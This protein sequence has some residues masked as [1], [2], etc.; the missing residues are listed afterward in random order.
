MPANA[1]DI[2]NIA[3]Y[4]WDA[5]GTFGDQRNPYSFA[6]FAQYQQLSSYRGQTYYVG[7]PSP[8]VFPYSDLGIFMFFGSTPFPQEYGGGGGK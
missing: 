8:L 4:Y 3:N 6:S 2:D 5:L 1:Y 7:N